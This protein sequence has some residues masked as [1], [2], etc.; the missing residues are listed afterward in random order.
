MGLRTAPAQPD[1]ALAVV[2][3]WGIKHQVKEI[4]PLFIPLHHFAL[5]T[6]K[7]IFKNMY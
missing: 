2:A 5:Q 3:T 6:N 1:T 4:S 7:Y